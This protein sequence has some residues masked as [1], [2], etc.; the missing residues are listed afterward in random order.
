VILSD[1]ELKER[2]ARGDLIVD[3]LHEP[4]VQIQPA[5]I[6]LRLGGVFLRGR[7]GT[8]PIDSHAPP[9]DLHDEVRVA[10]GEPLV[11][12]PGDFVLGSTLERVSVPRD[13]VARVEGRSSIGRLALLIHAT[14]GFIDPG[15]EG[16]ITLELANLGRLP[17]VLHP[18]MRVC[19]IAFHQLSSPVER[20]YGPTRGSKY[21]GQEGP[22]ASRMRPNR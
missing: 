9:P 8:G 15:F 4:D 7:D 12:G 22:T 5:S 21:H 6:D 13:L 16:E 20:P 17:V 2:L 11:L 14:A 3:P 18:G 1:R 10:P 19:Q